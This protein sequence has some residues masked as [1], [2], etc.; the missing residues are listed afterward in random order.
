MLRFLTSGE[1]HGRALVAILEGMPAG[2]PITEEEIGVQMARRQLGYGRGA[3]MKLEIDRAE[4]VSGVIRGETIGAPVALWI[5]NKDWRQDEPDITRPRPGHADLVGAQKHGFH[6]VRR[7]LER[8]SARE[9]AARVAVGT[10]CRKFCERFGML[11]LSHVIHVGGVSITRRPST[12]DEVPAL[13]EASELR[14]VDPEAE[15]KMRAVIDAAKERGDTLGGIVEIVATGV[16]AGLGTY[17]Q[18]DRRLDARLAAVMMSINAI[19]G[20]EVGLGF[21]SARTPGSAAHDEIFWSRERGFYRETNRAGGTEG[22]VSNGEPIVVKIA[23]KPLSTL[24]SPLRSVDL[25]TKEPIEAAV[26]RSDVTAVPAAGVV[27]EAMM[28]FVVA[29]LFLEK[30][31]GDSMAQVRASYDA[32]VRWLREM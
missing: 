4:I 30:F 18:W 15:A 29:D 3:R 14:C 16:P 17:A 26:V 13:A 32:Y 24:R 22:G 31:G 1:S 10:I 6:D 2:L 25:I 12:W 27:G 5:Q 21:E 11:F 28:A 23:M 8:S 19:K 7:V 20:V 9:T